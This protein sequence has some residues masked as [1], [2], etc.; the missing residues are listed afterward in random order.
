LIN[1]IDINDRYSQ[2]GLAAGIDPLISGVDQ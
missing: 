1:N 2:F